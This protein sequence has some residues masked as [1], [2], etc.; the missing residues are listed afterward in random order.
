M[1]TAVLMYHSVSAVDRGPLRTLAVPAPLLHEHLAALADAGYRLVGL[2]EAIDLRRAGST[3]PVVALTFDDGYADFLTRGLDVLKTVGATATLYM[4]VAHAG[5]PASW[6]G[7]RAWTFGPLLDWGQLR[8]VADAGVE[9]GNHSLIHHPLDTLTPP[10]LDRETAESRDRLMQ[11]VQQPIRSFCYPHGYHAGP[12][13]A[14]VARAGH[15][16]ACAIGRRLYRPGD[17]PLAVPRLQPTPEHSG[18]DLLRL[19][20]TGGPTLGPKLREAAQPAWR[21]TR[22]L[23]KQWFG[24]EFT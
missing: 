17:D 12:V 4:A 5:G 13:R 6:L 3:E 22:R 1:A 14:A 8:E 24:V 7:P 18:A 15:D 2:T 23:A 11:E 10:R 19:V 16:N 21:T 20:R 9:I